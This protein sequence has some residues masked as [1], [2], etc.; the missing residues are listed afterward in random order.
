MTQKKVQHEAILQ[1]QVVQY[2]RAIL[3]Q[4]I[5]AAI[6]NGS[7]RTATGKPAN[8]IAGLFP[9]FPDLAVVL[10]RGQIIFF[11]LKS[12]KGRLSEAQLSVHLKLQGLNH[13]CAVVRSIDDVRNALNAW[14]INT[15]ESINGKS[16]KLD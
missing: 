2:L 6:P 4:S 5:V 10:P 15:R 7:Q 13:S 12:E 8:A 14:G 9:G 3:P 1:K 11:E 16:N